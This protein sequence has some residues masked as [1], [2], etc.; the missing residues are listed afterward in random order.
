MHSQRKR[1]GEGGG[2]GCVGR[3]L[4]VP[5][6][7]REHAAGT[8][9]PPPLPQI[10]ATMIRYLSLVAVKNETQIAQLAERPGTSK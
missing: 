2:E 6:P 3:I 9:Y 8:S 7:P 1:G 4:Q 10:A 5:S